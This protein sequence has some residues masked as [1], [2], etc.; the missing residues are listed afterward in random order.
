MKDYLEMAE[1]YLPKWDKKMAE[2]LVDFFHL[3][4]KKK[5]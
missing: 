1:A 4:K 3:D 2:E 5:L